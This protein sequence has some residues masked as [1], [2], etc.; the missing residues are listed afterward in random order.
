[1]LVMRRLAPCTMPACSHA[2]QFHLLLYPLQARTYRV[3]HAL[4]RRPEQKGG[5]RLDLIFRCSCLKALT[6]SL[7]L[8]PFPC[9]S[10]DGCDNIQ[11][12]NS[13]RCNTPKRGA[14]PGQDRAKS[15]V[16]GAW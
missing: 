2:T 11:E 4:R 16:A 3:R 12:I 15:R 8:T 10:D 13:R 14:G 1:M 7:P 9:R 5:R 6:P